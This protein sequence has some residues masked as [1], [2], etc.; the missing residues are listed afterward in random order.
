MTDDTRTPH[1]IFDSINKEH[2][3]LAAAMR[4]VAAEVVACFQK[5]RQ[6]PEF[7]RLA[8]LKDY[9]PGG[10]PIN[11]H[12]NEFLGIATRAPTAIQMAFPT[13]LPNPIPAP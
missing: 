5:I 13:E 8:E 1:E 12:V 10:S 7:Q 11:Q 2:E 9:V 3:A 6:S 4:P